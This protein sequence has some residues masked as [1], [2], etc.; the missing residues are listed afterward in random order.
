L[1]VALWGPLEWAMVDNLWQGLF[2]KRNSWSGTN[3]AVAD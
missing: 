2:G 3:M 1:T